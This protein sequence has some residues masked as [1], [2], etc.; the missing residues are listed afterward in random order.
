V[1]KKR[2]LMVCAGN[3]CRSP[4]AEYLLKKRI[5]DHGQDAHSLEV[6]S[7][8]T[9]TYNGTFAGDQTIYV[10]Q[11]RGLDISRH[12]TRQVDEEILEWADLVLCMEEGQRDLLRS[13]F[14][15]AGNKTHLIT[16]YCDGSGDILDPTGK[17][18]SAYE[19]CARRLEDLL[20]RLLE[21]ISSP[22]EEP[23]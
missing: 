21:K 9:S 23:D 7:A 16:E 20:A 8:G 1:R 10:M 15:Q 14:P 22:L 17:P 13:S 6:R 5:R 4:M 19:E 12:R 2:I 11:S 18:T 3:I